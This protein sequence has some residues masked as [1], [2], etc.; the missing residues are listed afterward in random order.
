MLIENFIKHICYKF[1]SKELKMKIAINTIIDYNNYGNRLQNY[2]LQETLKKQGHEVETIRNYYDISETLPLKFFNLIKR[3]EL[4]RKISKKIIPSTKKEAEKQKMLSENRKDK[5]LKF[6]NQYITETQLVLTQYTEDFS[7]F[8][9]FDMFIIGSDQV[10]NYNFSRFSSFD[11]ISFSD[12]PKI[13]YA[14]SFGVS[15]IPKEYWNLYREGLNNLSEI[16]VREEAGKKIVETISN[17][18]AEVV[19]DPTMLLNR[20]EWEKLTRGFPVINQKKYILTYFLDSPTSDDIRYIENF[21]LTNECEVKNLVDIKDIKLWLADP[22]EFIYLFQHAEA[23][24][25]DSFHACVFSIIF[26]KYFEVFERNTTLPSMNSRIDTLFDNLSMEDRWHKADM[27]K[28]NYNSVNIELNKK[29]EKSLEF[30][31]RAIE[32]YS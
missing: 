25:T 32:K 13:S 31:K 28:I 15:D 26:E 9:K 12:K 23:V 21:A 22:A 20:E 4:F 5:F 6:T 18:N 10:W 27:K 17:R 24:F 16:S 3:G 11:F 30:L 1:I 14:A 7:G 29:R 19:L 8:D 2:A